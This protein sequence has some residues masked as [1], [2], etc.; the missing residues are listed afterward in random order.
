MKLFSL[1]IKLSVFWRIFGFSFWLLLWSYWYC[2]LKMLILYWNKL[3]FIII[4]IIIIIIILALPLTI[5]LSSQIK[6]FIKIPLKSTI[7]II[8]NLNWVLLQ[9]SMKSNKFLWIILWF[10]IFFNPSKVII[11]GY[12]SE[13]VRGVWWFW[14][15]FVACV[16][17]R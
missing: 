11:F 9:R 15:I 8:F 10:L 1:L 14:I 13:F 5:T 2:F 6:K 7:F 16:R 3:I 17:N 4:N 12:F